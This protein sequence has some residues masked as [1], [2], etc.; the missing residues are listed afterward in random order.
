MYLHMDAA[1]H[2]LTVESRRRRCQLSLI[3]YLVWLEVVYGI[4]CLAGM[5]L[6]RVFWAHRQQ[7]QHDFFIFSQSS[8]Q[9]V[10]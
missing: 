9:Q 2:T 8:S 6:L 10:P 3:N 5:H 4:F 7:Q 1:A